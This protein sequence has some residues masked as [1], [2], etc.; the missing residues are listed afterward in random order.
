M[1]TYIHTY[2]CLSSPL[3]YT[4]RISKN[5]AHSFNKLRQLQ[6]TTCNLR[7]VPVVKMKAGSLAVSVPA[8]SV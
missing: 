8:P 7:Y 2:N 1:H 4:S 6:S 5:D 3:I